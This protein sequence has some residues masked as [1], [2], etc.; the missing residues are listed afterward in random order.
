M[1]EY[2]YDTF[3]RSTGYA[4]NGVRQTTID[5]DS[6]GRISTMTFRQPKMAKTSTLQLQLKAPTLS[7]GPT[8]KEAT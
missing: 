3:G 1:I 7:T 5:Y 8:S 4:I 6:F 2:Y